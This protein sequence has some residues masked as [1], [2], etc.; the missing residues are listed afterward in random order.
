MASSAASSASHSLL[1]TIDRGAGSAPPPQD[2]GHAGLTEPADATAGGSASAAEPLQSFAL[3]P[4]RAPQRSAGTP[5]VESPVG[6][7]P[8]VADI[9]QGAADTDGAVQPADVRGD[10]PSGPHAAEQP[11]SVHALAHFE[12]REHAAIDPVRLRAPR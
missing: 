9:A 10:A 11:P 2:G 8:K 6:P 12:T 3:P 5:G 4:V 1:P 7:T